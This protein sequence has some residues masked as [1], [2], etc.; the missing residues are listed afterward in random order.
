MI[1]YDLDSTEKALVEEAKR[2]NG[3]IASCVTLEVFTP[4][5]QKRHDALES[6]V[7]KGYFRMG[8]P[9]IYRLIT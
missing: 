3:V 9:G 4:E 2:E 8:E 5:E 6:L 7:V 1:Y